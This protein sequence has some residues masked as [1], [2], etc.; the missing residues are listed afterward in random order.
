V[1]DR[2]AALLAPAIISL[3]AGAAGVSKRLEG[4]GQRDEPAVVALAEAIT[5]QATIGRAVV[6]ARSRELAQAFI[7]ELS[8]LPDVKMWTHAAHSAA[9]VSFQPGSLNPSRLAAALYKEHRIACASR[10]G[11][12]RPGI[13]VS[14]HVYNLHEDVDRTVAAIK[15][16][17]KTGV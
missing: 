10:G 14:P 3:Y 9:V 5:L 4:Y 16:Y 11:A 15:G 7:R 6:E 2:A 13:R 12:D 1:N 8:K 17:L